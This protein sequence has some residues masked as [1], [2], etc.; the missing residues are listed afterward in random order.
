MAQ[1]STIVLL[2]GDYAERLSQK[3]EAAKAAEAFDGPLLAGEEHPRDVIAAEYEALKA[4]AEAASKEAERTVTLAAVARPAMRELRVKHPAR[5][6][7]DPDAVKADRIARLNTETV[8]DDLLYAS[9]VVPK[10]TS[11]AQ[12]DEWADSLS[13]GEFRTLVK[14]AWQLANVAL[15]DPKSLPHWQIPSGDGS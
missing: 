13:E 10:F 2:T 8:E 4:E 9:V 6:E 3:A 1:T 12:F 14:R 7:G 5:T 11:R 15:I